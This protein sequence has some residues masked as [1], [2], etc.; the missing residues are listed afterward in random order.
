M[1]NTTQVTFVTVL[2]QAIGLLLVAGLMLPIARAVQGRYLVYW[3][4]G[5]TALAMGLFG[6]YVYLM[7]GSTSL[8]LVMLTSLSQYFFGFLLWAGCRNAI[9]HERLCLTRYAAMVPLLIFAIVGPSTVGEL[10]YFHPFHSVVIAMLFTLAFVTV[11][12]TPPSQSRAPTIGLWTIRLSILGLAFLFWHYAFVHSYHL[13]VTETQPPIY[14]NYQTLYEVLFE[15]VLAFG[16]VIL[17]TDRMRGELEAK[18][19][20][21]AEA[22]KE[23]SVVARLDSLTGL[24]N[25][26]AFEELLTNQTIVP[27]FGS[28]A[29]IDMNDLKPLNDVYGHAAGDIALKLLARALQFHF[30]T[31]DPMFRIGGDE[32]AIVM[33]GCQTVDLCSRLT[34]LEKYLQRQR[35]PGLDQPRDISIAWGVAE[36]SEPAELLVA[37]QKA[38]QAM[39]IKKRSQ[40]AQPY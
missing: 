23:Q 26:R 32:F 15:I 10:N 11:S 20:L 25:R 6:Q 4:I 1:G 5:W 30:R 14:L 8:L 18:N 7:E 22:V 21:L 12:Q 28:L 40:K 34:L 9:H 29:I 36:Y 31:S 19:Q 13:F 17:G 24:H 2:I 37:Y 38:D 27:S 33:L 16:M 35:L 39:Y 3:S